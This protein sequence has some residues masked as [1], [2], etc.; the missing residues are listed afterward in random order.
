MRKKLF[1][2]ILIATMVIAGCGAKVSEESVTNES[3]SVSDSESAKVYDVSSVTSDYNYNEQSETQT[4]EAQEPLVTDDDFETWGYQYEVVGSTY[5]YVVV[6]NNSELPVGINGNAV[7][8]DSEGNIM[9]EGSMSISVLGPGETTIEEF[10]F[11]D[12]VDI[13]EVEYELS[14]N[15]TPGYIPILGDLDIEYT[16]NSKNVSIAVRNNGE[17]TAR[18]LKATCLL[19]DADNN[20]IRTDYGYIGSDFTSV[21][22]GE[23]VYEQVNMYALEEGYD[24]AEVY[25]GGY[26]EEYKGEKV[27]LADSDIDVTKYSLASTYG[28]SVEYYLVITNNSSE[29][30][31]VNGSGVVKDA[32]G[33]MLDTS[34]M[35]D[36]DVLAPGET[37]AGWMYFDGIDGEIADMEYA[38]YYEKEEYYKPVI[39]NLEVD[40][41]G[42]NQSATVSVTNNGNIPAQFV[43]ASVLFLDEN[44]QLVGGNTNF[45]ID[46]DNEIKAGGTVAKEFTTYEPFDSVEVYFTGRG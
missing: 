13:Y 20:V 38:L 7:A 31:S 32:S 41:Q 11:H 40:I 1:P 19:F 25:F 34:G 35:T 3:V 10:L 28:N 30:V 26:G 4:T 33:N 37:T 15:V 14:Y 43:E 23:T 22:P 29:T 21:Y 16:A 6:K 45:I 12:I 24:H 36:I 27:Q 2:T 5:Y 8:K 39:G 42:E 44:G 17:Y 46:D 9:G 18:Y